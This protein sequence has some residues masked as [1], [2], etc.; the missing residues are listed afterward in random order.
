MKAQRGFSLAEL[1]IAIV[2]GLF[3][4][5]ATFS[6][7]TISSAS[8]R[9]TGQMTQ[10][11]EAARLALRLLEEDLTQAG[12]FSDLSAIDLSPNTNT[13]LH[14]SV[15][16]VDCVGGGQQQR[17]VSQWN[18]TLSNAVGGEARLP[19]GDQL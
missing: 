9:S 11:Q 2:I 18:G 13:T 10:L 15:T 3:L 12:F 19:A 6:V 17:H 5:A 16:G 7:L 4:I 8:V 14:G 1:L